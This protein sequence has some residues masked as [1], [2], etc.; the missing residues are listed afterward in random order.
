MSSIHCGC[1]TAVDL[2]SGSGAVT[3]GLVLGGFRVAAAVDKDPVACATYR[4]NHPDVYL[5]EEDIKAVCPGQIRTARLGGRN[6]DLLVIC[7]PCQ[8]FSSQNRARN[9]DSRVLLILQSIRFV[10][11]LKPKLIFFENVPGL[12]TPRHADL[13]RRLG[14]GLALHGYHLSEPLRIDAAD[15]GVPQRRLRCIMLAAQRTLSANELPHRP[16]NAARCTVRDTIGTLPR[17]NSG[18][19]DAGDILH[20]ARTHRPIALDRL[21]Q[22]PKNGGS[23]FALPL[24]LE[25]DCHSGHSGHPDVYGRMAW[26]DVAPTLT[27]GCTDVTRG[28]FAH[29]ED[30][31]A[32]TLREAALLQT[33]PTS[34]QFSGNASQ[35]AT[36]IGNAVP[37]GLVLSLSP[38]LKS[39]IAG[40]VAVSRPSQH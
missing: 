20:R 30:D 33:F 10:E 5:Y 24:R 36:Q 9:A 40:A 21:A 3:E 29:P 4:L 23:R 19:K 31:R 13:I 32:I 37:V 16:P 6:V 25:L 39:I 18:E 38:T 15:Y 27:T 2:Y 28:R 8:P 35:I 1:P 17:L 22:I 7:A 11:V 34:Y 14:Q 26:D 12:A